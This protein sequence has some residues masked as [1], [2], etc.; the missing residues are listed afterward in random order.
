M[1]LKLL[2]WLARRTPNCREMSRLASLSLERSLPLGTRLRMRLHFFIC[3]WCHRYFRQLHS[4]HEVAPHLP[5]H[6]S[7]TAGRLSAEAKQRLRSRL[8]SAN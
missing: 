1:K 7:P 2:M 5:E 3:V 8:K 4:M 6:P